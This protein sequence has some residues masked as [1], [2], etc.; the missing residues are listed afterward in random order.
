MYDGPMETVEYIWVNSRCM[1]DWIIGFCHTVDRSGIQL[2]NKRGVHKMR[3]YCVEI[4]THCKAEHLMAQ[5]CETRI[6]IPEVEL[7]WMLV[8]L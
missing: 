2:I 6:F 4:Q 8:R 1:L 3:R 5:H 7:K